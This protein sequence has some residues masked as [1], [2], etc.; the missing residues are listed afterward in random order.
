MNEPLII[1]C[2]IDGVLCEGPYLPV[3]ERTAERYAAMRPY[4]DAIA[5]FRAERPANAIVYYITSRR[6][7]LWRTTLHWLHTHVDA[8][9]QLIAGVDPERKCIVAGQLGCR[10]LFDDDPNA[11]L[12]V[13]WGCGAFLVHNPS[14]DP[15]GWDVDNIGQ[16][17]EHVR[18]YDSARKFYTPQERRHARP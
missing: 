9:A 5:R 15:E 12:G 6:R 7:H 16:A 13:T 17:W 2:D 11:V 4:T 3:E 10:Y 18:F 8:N 1:A 14:R